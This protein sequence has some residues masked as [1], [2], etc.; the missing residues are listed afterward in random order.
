MLRITR[1]EITPGT[2]PQSVSIKTINIEPHPWSI[3][4]KGGKKIDNKTLKFN[5]YEPSW[6]WIK[7]Y[8]KDD[9]LEKFIYNSDLWGNTPKKYPMFGEVLNKK[10]RFFKNI[11]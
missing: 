5:Y 8:L 1:A 4:A 3:T 2:H 10:I 11:F 6:E 9:M 7:Q